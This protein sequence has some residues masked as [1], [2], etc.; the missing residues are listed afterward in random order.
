MQHVGP[1]G[2]DRAGHVTGHSWAEIGPAA[3]AAK[4]DLGGAEPLVEA[5]RVAARHVEAQ[6]ACVD[7]GRTQ[8]GEQCEQVALRPADAGQLVEVEDLHASS[9]R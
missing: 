2:P 7:P 6:E 1:L 3:D 5:R 4:R 8:R 9:C